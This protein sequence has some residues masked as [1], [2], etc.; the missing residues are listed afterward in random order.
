MVNGKLPV[1]AFSVYVY[2]SV[3]SGSAGVVC[4]SL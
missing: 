3:Q 4:V 1:Y 2:S